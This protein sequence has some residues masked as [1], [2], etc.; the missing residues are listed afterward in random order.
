MK[1]L[2]ILALLLVSA[3]EARHPAWV[4]YPF[5]EQVQC[6]LGMGSA[7]RVADGSYVSA[8][9][10]MSNDLCTVGGKAVQMTSNNGGLDFATFTLP[11]KRRKG[12]AIDCAGVQEGHW[13]YAIGYAR[14]WPRQQMMTLRS[15]GEAVFADGRAVL[16]GDETVIP[17]QSGGAILNERGELV[18]IIN[19]Y[20][21]D[22]YGLASIGRELKDTPLCA[23]R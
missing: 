4:N 17:G 10:V 6:D 20:G 16:R 11:G 22:G 1:V 18:A 9:H 13:Y 23:G 8:S 2:A 12:V 3:A 19:A 7:V 21:R 5:V 15:R 14:G